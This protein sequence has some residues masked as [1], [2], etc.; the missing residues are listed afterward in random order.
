MSLRRTTVLL[1]IGLVGTLYLVMLPLRDSDT[2]PLSID[3]AVLSTVTDS[4][5][6]PTY[7]P[8][9]PSSARLSVSPSVS[10]SVRPSFRPS[11]TPTST[12]II[13]DPRLAHY[14]AC[15]AKLDPTNIMQFAHQAN[16]TT[17]AQFVMQSCTSCTRSYKQIW[18]EFAPVCTRVNSL[19]DKNAQ[20]RKIPWTLVENSF[21]GEASNPSC[22]DFAQ[23][24]QAFHLGRRVN[25]K[26]GKNATSAYEPSRFIPYKCNPE[27]MS[28]QRALEVLNKAGSVILFGDSKTRI[29]SQSLNLI[30]DE[31]LY[32]G[33]LDKGPCEKCSCDGIFG[34]H[35]ACYSSI[36]QVPKVHPKAPNVWVSTHYTSSSMWKSTKVLKQ[37][38]E[39]S[40][41]KGKTHVLFLQGGLHLSV[42]ASLAI[43][44]FPRLIRTFKDVVHEC[45]PTA[46]AEVFFNGVGVQT[47]VMDAKYPHQADAKVQVYN[48]EV[49]AVLEGLGV[50][51]LDFAPLTRNGAK[52]DGVHSLADIG[53]YK[54]VAYLNG[55][56]MLLK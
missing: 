48:A 40:K 17:H 15:L 25:L 56:E 33:K 27:Y 36:S 51:V 28:A 22:R 14:K 10:P 31:N 39:Q 37:A 7:R 4:S 26:D 46:K 3:Q 47:P 23:V 55:L 5:S 44:E 21:E 43:V 49:G 42:N 32:S 30:L 50:K 12:P 19:Y 29:I 8:S 11:S 1:M 6:S 24:K 2:P 13:Q 52:S 45:D 54:A 38:C 34:N 35:N 18:R 20:F 41:S 9:R 16:S 53:L